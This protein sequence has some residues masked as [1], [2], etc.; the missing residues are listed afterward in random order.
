MGLNLHRQGVLWRDG[1]MAGV[2]NR[3]KAWGF[4]RMFVVKRR[5][6]ELSSLH[7]AVCAVQGKRHSDAGTGLALQ[8]DLAAGG[9]PCFGRCCLGWP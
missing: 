3:L 9:G 4:A 7:L 2:K 8:Q 5:T 1:E 6:G